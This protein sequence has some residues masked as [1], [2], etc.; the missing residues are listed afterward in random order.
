MSNKNIIE[1]NGKK[2]DALT[3]AALESH[4]ETHIEN[5]HKPKVITD[6]K[7]IYHS[8]KIEPRRAHDLHHHTAKAHTLKRE[9]VHKPD[10]EQAHNQHL[11]THV[12]STVFSA[13]PPHIHPSSA[14][15]ERLERASSV[16]QSSKISRFGKPDELHVQKK[17][18]ILDVVEAPKQIS[19]ST[20]QSHTKPTDN[21]THTVASPSSAHTHITQPRTPTIHATTR[22]NKTPLHHR[23]RH[24]L[25]G[26]TYA[27]GIV[28]AGL[29]ALL[30]GSFFAYQHVPQVALQ[31][32]ERQAGIEGKLPQTLSGYSMKKPIQYSNGQITISFASN[33][34]NRSYTVAERTSNWNSEALRI[35]FVA[36]KSVDYESM[37]DRGRT[38]F[39]YGGNNAT[40]VD[41]GIWYEVEGN[42]SMSKSQL[43]QIIASL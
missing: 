23:I 24:K 31:V 29:A 14:N 10:Q 37:L 12:S 43:L 34:D 7:P 32:A 42:E 41:G 18:Q 5:P 1:I 9:L 2:Y 17:Q 22:H 35:N 16:L 40:W 4:S 39:F 13:P 26:R 33:S 8:E 36:T 27:T 30:F 25:I 19:S 38:I 21:H 6:V 15:Q 28:T 3:G 11:D 20:H